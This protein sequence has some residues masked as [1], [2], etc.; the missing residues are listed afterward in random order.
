[1]LASAVPAVAGSGNDDK[2]RAGQ[3]SSPRPFGP[4]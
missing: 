4:G 1:M 3:P 2:I